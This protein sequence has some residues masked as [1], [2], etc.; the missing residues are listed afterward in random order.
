MGCWMDC[1]ASEVVFWRDAEVAGG[2]CIGICC[3][4]G[5]KFD[6]PGCMDL[7]STDFTPN[8]SAPG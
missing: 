3:E 1:C 7:S 5:A 6:I 4:V 8:S 2:L